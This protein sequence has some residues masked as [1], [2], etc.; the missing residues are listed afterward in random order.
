MHPTAEGP[1]SRLGVLGGTFD[2]L[3]IGHLV[4]A[5][6]ALYAFELD[7][8]LFVPAG[9]PWQKPSYSDA[10]DRFMMTSLG[11]GGH[12]RFATSRIELDRPGLTF[13]VDTMT[14]LRDFHGPETQLFFIAGIDAVQRLGTWEGIELLAGL[15]ELIA[16]SRPG[17]ELTDWE[18]RPEWPKVRNLEV[19]GIGVSSTDIRVRVDT[20]RPIDYLVP[21]EV[22][23]YI[24]DHRLYS[25]AKA[26]AGG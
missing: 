5:S 24:L 23:R 10:E 18:P 12:P 13:T 15:T 16:V 25:D 14:A 4:V 19:P 21:P 8:V 22:A 26:A 1:L 6:E 3:H 9:R 11:V 17:L 2:P 20:G 7:Q